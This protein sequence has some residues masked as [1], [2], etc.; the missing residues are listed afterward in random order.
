VSRTSDTSRARAPR[1]CIARTATGFAAA[2]SV[3]ALLAGCGPDD[4]PAPKALPSPSGTAQAI[5][6]ANLVH[7][8][9][10]RID[11]GTIAC[12]LRHGDADALFITPTGK[13]YALNDQADHD[14]YPSIDPLL[15]DGAHLGAIRSLA[16]RLC[17]P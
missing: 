7:L 10:L 14:G 1:R 2:L 15:H 13:R 3:A 4:E 8:W 16:L 5:S 9:P 6:R 12:H 17:S 11:H